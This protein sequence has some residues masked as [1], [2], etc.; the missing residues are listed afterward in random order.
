MKAC[1][2]LK[3]GILLGA[4]QSRQCGECAPAMSLTVSIGR[5]SWGTASSIVCSGLD[6]WVWSFP[7]LFRRFYPHVSS[8]FLFSSSVCTHPLHLCVRT[9]VLVCPSFPDLY[10]IAL[11]IVFHFLCCSFVF[12]D[13]FRCLRIWCLTS[14][15]ILNLTLC[16][17]TCLPLRVLRLSLWLSRWME[18]WMGLCMHY[19]LVAD[20]GKEVICAASALQ[21][22]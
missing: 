21:G 9:L 16:F 5:T 18:I 2:K 22:L 7:V 1:N 4:G 19:N 14:A 11:R 17:S 8:V 20:K 12:L 13:S 15:F 3:H 10:P 6:F